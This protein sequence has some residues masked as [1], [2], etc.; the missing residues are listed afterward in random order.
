MWGESNCP[1]QRAINHLLRQFINW[2]PKES[3]S[4]FSLK[5]PDCDTQ[6]ILVSDDGTVMGIIIDWDNI[7][8]APR[9]NGSDAFPLWLMKDWDAGNLV[10]LPGKY[11]FIAPE[12][13]AQYREQY[14]SCM[15]RWKK[16]ADSTKYPNMTKV[17][18]VANCL[19]YVARFIY[20]TTNGGYKPLY[21]IMFEI[22]E[23]AAKDRRSP[24]EAKALA[25]ELISMEVCGK[26]GEKP[27]RLTHQLARRLESNMASKDESDLLHDGFIALIC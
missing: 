2:L 20:S 21:K 26:K 10:M 13:F 27:E 17:S 3:T 8:I 4:K 7:H 14:F 18:L 11:D 1:N 16:D 24:A 22:A 25:A 12:E 5:H 23:V 19:D 9:S 15:A 6:N